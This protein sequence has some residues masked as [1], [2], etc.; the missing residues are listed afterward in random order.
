MRHEKSRKQKMPRLS[1]CRDYWTRTSD[2]TPP[3]R[4]R[5]LLR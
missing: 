1:A 5:Y 2:L 4:V 3:R